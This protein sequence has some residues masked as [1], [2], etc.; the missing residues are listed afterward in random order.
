MKII[1]LGCILIIIL[2]ILDLITTKIFLSQGIQEWNVLAIFLLA[3]FGFYFLVIIKIVGLI[4]ILALIKLCYKRY[5]QLAIA[6]TYFC[7]GFYTL[8]IIENIYVI[9]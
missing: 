9:L 8:G 2:N 4:I 3:R 1:S 7:V 5:K 6:A